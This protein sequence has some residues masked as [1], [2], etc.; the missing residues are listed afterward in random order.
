MCRAR[1]YDVHDS[2][3]PPR[4]VQAGWKTCNICSTC[5]HSLNKTGFTLSA[6]K[7]QV[8][9]HHHLTCK[10]KNVL[11]IVECTKCQ[12]R[13]QYIGK[14]RRTLMERGREHLNAIEKNKDD[15]DTRSTSKMYA[16]FASKG[17]STAHFRIFAVEQIFEDDFVS[18]S[19][20]RSLINRGDTIR[21]G[22]NTYRT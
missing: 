6:T 10:T 22:L 15:G 14:T 17:H 13:P 18:M 3:N 9:I 11:Y 19:R 21:K 16:H 12:D 20:E 4:M 5:Q 2:R 1:L 8:S 7:V